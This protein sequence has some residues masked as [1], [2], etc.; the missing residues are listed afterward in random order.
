MKEDDP[1]SLEINWRKNLLLPG[2]AAFVGASLSLVVP[3]MALCGGVGGKSS[4]VPFYAGIAVA[5]LPL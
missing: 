3:F 2:L 4:A 1:I 5:S